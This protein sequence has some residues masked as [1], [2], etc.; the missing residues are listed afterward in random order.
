M[1]TIQPQYTSP[2]IKLTTSEQRTTITTWTYSQ[3][4]GSLGPS[5]RCGH[6]TGSQ[7]RPRGYSRSFLQRSYADTRSNWYQI[8]TK[9]SRNNE[10]VATVNNQKALP[11]FTP[12]DKAKSQRY[13][14]SPHEPTGLV[15]PR[16]GFLFYDTKPS[17]SHQIQAREAFT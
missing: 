15:P 7:V 1:H 10:L 3:Q 14:P 4:K 13:N 2:M 17:H 9:P 5:V 12:D 6:V 11:A 16:A 8:Q